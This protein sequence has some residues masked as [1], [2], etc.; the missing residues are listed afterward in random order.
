MYGSAVDNSV[1][2]KCQRRAIERRRCERLAL[3][4][5]GVALVL[6]VGIAGVVG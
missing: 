3:R 6:L 5:S 2:M 4:L 1:W